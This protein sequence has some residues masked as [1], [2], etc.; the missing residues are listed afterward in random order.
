VARAGDNFSSGQSQR[1]ALARDLLKDAPI[2]ILDEATSNLDG[3]TKH[4][5]LQ[6]L[7]ANRHGRTTIVIAHRL[8]TVVS[9][10][11]IFVMDDGEIVEMGTHQEL[12]RRRGRYFDLFHWQLVEA[13]TLGAET[14]LLLAVP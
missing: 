7:A 5:I 9:A 13:A 8:S 4:A 1:I 10:D 14:P 12:L 11:R 3:E 2:L 6:A